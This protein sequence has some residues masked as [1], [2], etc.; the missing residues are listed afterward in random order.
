EG[1]RYTLPFSHWEGRQLAARWPCGQVHIGKEAAWGR[2]PEWSD[3]ALVHFS[4]HGSGYAH[5]APLSHLRLADDLLLAHD[6]LYR[7]PPL[8][9]G[10]VVILNGCETGSRDT[11]AV[12][13]G[14][15]LMSAFLLR[16]A[17]LVMSTLWPID[18]AVAAEV[19]LTF[20]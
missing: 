16:G 19:V 12:D 14:M 6:V 8:K 5:F 20:L 13:E 11:R 15:G 2:V 4:C 7:L 9:R 10:A 18:D 17:S 3:A 1:T